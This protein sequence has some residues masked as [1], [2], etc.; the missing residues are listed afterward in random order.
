VPTGISAVSE[1]PGRRRPNKVE[2]GKVRQCA[3]AGLARN[4][5]Q[6][7]QSPAAKWHAAQDKRGQ[8]RTHTAIEDIPSTRAGRHTA[9]SPVK[10]GHAQSGGTF[11]SLVSWDSA[12]VVM[13]NSLKLF[14]MIE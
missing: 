4:C 1:Q 8:A 2:A 13:P 7:R 14:V 6:A 3:P 12:H 11:V 5:G 10:H 9:Q